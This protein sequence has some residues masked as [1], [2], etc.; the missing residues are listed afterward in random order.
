M[1]MHI[2]YW[3]VCLLV[4]CKVGS[5][6]QNNLSNVGVRLHLLMGL[7]NFLEIKNPLFCK[8]WPEIGELAMFSRETSIG[9]TESRTGLRLPSK[10]P[11]RQSLK[12]W[13]L[14]MYPWDWLVCVFVCRPG[15]SS[16]QLC[17][18]IIR[19]WPKKGANQIYHLFV[20][21]MSCNPRLNTT[22]EFGLNFAV[23]KIVVLN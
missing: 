11:A 20:Y 17:F 3:Y 13:L 6:L 4:N 21:E 12:I 16:R 19:P 5:H 7:P 8:F 14:F 9:N 22:K 18:V 23:F 2:L 15:K 10:N 1:T